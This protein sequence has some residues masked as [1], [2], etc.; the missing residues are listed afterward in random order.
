MLPASS[1]LWRGV[2]QRR[3]LLPLVSQKRGSGREILQELLRTA[4]SALRS[5][6]GGSSALRTEAILPLQHA[7]AGQARLRF[8]PRHRDEHPKTRGGKDQP[9]RGDACSRDEKVLSSIHR[10]PELNF[11]IVVKEPAQAAR[12][13]QLALDHF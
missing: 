4:D 8:T 1:R 2:G 13:H 5:S 10:V 9:E 3:D 6:T 12:L 7:A 11:E